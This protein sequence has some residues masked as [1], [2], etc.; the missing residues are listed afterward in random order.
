MI[1]VA[2]LLDG[3]SMSDRQY[4][5]TGSITRNTSQSKSD[6]RMKPIVDAIAVGSVVTNSASVE[7]SL[8][9][10]IGVGE[11]NDFLVNEQGQ[12]LTY[13][14]VEAIIEVR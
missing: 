9:M 13:Q 2:Q 14:Q 7:S 5:I 8:D 4:V 3:P 12:Y 10:A 11:L 1:V 6:S